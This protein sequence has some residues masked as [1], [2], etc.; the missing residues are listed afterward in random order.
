MCSSASSSDGDC[1]SSSLPTEGK[2]MAGS[3]SLSVVSFVCNL[4]EWLIR[5]ICRS[6]QQ[7]LVFFTTA[8]FACTLFGSSK[9]TVT[10]PSLCIFL[11]FFKRLLISGNTWYTSFSST[12]G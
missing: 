11:S 10:C 8:L 5:R 7:I 1:S 3:D 4:L 12:L 6:S 2:G 9:T